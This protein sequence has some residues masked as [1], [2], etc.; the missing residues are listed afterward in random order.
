MGPLT[1]LQV[2]ASGITADQMW[3]DVVASNLANM[4]TTQT[5]GGTPYREES[6]V[7]APET[8]GAALAGQGVQVTA[9]T[10]S[11]AP[12]KTVYD[13]TSPLANAQ[14][15]VQMS[16]VNETAQMADL[17]AASASM[18]ANASAMGVQV[19]EIQADFKVLQGV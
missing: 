4:N 12:F 11:N 1:G 13:P 16:N 15:Y 10:Q 18:A 6:V 8:F 2:S 9:I 19:Q 5:P 14:G 3:T 7:T 17:T